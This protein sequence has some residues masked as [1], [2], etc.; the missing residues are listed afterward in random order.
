MN[1]FEV[2]AAL[3]KELDKKEHEISVLSIGPAGENLVKFACLFNDLGHIAAHNG[4]GAV[5]G[6]KKLKA[7][8]VERGKHPIQLY[9]KE[10]LAR[11]AKDLLDNVLSTGFGRLTHAEGTVGLIPMSSKAMHVVPVKN[12]TTNNNFM[13]DAVLEDF[14]TKSVRARFRARPEPC[15]ACRA[16]HCHMME[17]TEGKYAG[18]IFE[19]PEYEGMAACSTVVGV[20]DITMTVVLASEIDRLGLDTN[21]A[22]WVM[23]F[24]I[25]CYEKGILTKKDTDGLELTWGNGEAL[26]ALL[27]KIAHREGI[28]NI[29]AEGVMRAAQKIGGQ[30]RELAIHTAK[31][32]TPRGHDHRAN[33]W[34]MFDTIVSNTGTLE[35]HGGVPFKALGLNPQYDKFDPEAVS[36][37][38]AKGKGAMIFEDSM[39]TCRYNT[40]TAIDLL[41]QAVNAATGWNLDVAEAL[42][43]GKRAVN[44]ARVFNIRHGVP[45]ELD[46]PSIR[47][48]STL[49]D[50]PFAGK[51]IMPHL[52]MMLRNYYHNMG[53]DE[54]T[55]KPLPQTLTD[56]GLD[57]VIPDL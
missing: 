42:T 57:F 47:Y 9:N 44:L 29:L 6:S 46:T 38:V 3:K 52:D 34:E 19:E 13:T 35:A 31:G 56:L 33:W 22:G 54:K 40:S 30:A 10:A 11:A 23:G 55:G 2:D 20:E 1:N 18:R 36:T 14:T 25:E 50:G 48:G 4:V 12:Y 21:E 8:V 15:W 32:N 39:Y 24:A 28:G 37:L 7:I 51:G 53:W 17:I 43:I 5:M 16:K 26:M 27:N 49:T 41:C 45:S